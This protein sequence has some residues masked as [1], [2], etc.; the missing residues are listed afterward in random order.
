MA[1]VRPLY[2]F[3]YG[4]R[5]S[6]GKP[7]YRIV[8]S[9][10]DDIDYR[11]VRDH[12]DK[13]IRVPCGHCVGCRLDKA[14]EWANRM[15]LELRDNDGLA[16]FC[17]FTYNDGFVP[18][19][20]VVDKRTGE[21]HEYMTLR[22]RDFQLFMKRLRKAFPEDCIRYYAAGEYGSETFRPHYHAIIYGLHL[23][24][25]LECRRDVAKNFVYYRSESLQDVWSRG[26]VEVSRVEW[27]TCSYV[28][29]YTMKKQG[30][31]WK[32]CWS[33]FGLEA[34]FSLMSRKPG[35][36]RR[37]YDQHPE[38]YTKQSISLSL[39]KGGLTFSLP[40]YY[41]RLIAEEYP[42]LSDARKEMRREIARSRQ[43]LKAALS[44]LDE[45]E[46]SKV[47]E[48]NLLS[49]IKPLERRL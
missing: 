32:D 21:A 38:L 46:Q 17:T 1:C 37:Y 15:M 2:G 16:Y 36:G 47:D 10:L 7:H 9:V 12:P 48:N 28:A 5:T 49:R 44:S 39:P 29:R 34:P 18:K 8:S 27:N 25:L 41:E 30:D 11:F 13:V 40:K 14:A 4:Y 35:I 6:N 19:E 33:E 20:F 26:F 45:Y 3:D 24:D 22:K 23:N 43:D 31:H 42:E